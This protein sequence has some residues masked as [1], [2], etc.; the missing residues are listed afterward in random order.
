MEFKVLQEPNRETPNSSSSSRGL[1]VGQSTTNA[2]HSIS[3]PDRREGPTASEWVRYS[4]VILCHGERL[5]S[6]LQPPKGRSQNSPSV[7][8]PQVSVNQ[9][10]LKKPKPSPLNSSQPPPQAHSSPPANPHLRRPHTNQPLQQHFGPPET[11]ESPQ[12]SSS[13][14]FQQKQP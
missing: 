7:V 12:T 4:I 6:I 13:C 11:P 5:P 3:Q 1:R 2:L 9:L 10:T 8:A 14:P